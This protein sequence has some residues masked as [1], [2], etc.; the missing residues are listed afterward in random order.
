MKKTRWHGFTL[1]IGVPACI[2][3]LALLSSCL[4][5]KE[6]FHKE[7][8]VT[9][10]IDGRAAMVTDTYCNTQNVETEEELQPCTYLIKYRMDTYNPPYSSMW[11]KE[12]EIEAVEPPLNFSGCYYSN[13]IDSKVQIPCELIK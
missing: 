12:F 11:V 2:L 4:T 1:L 9:M 6:K 8:M 10:R 3:S 7:Q 13:G 5:P